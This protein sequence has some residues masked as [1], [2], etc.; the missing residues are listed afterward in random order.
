MDAQ[1][2][3]D[4]VLLSRGS[5]QLPGHCRKPFFTM[6]LFSEEHMD[7]MNYVKEV[8][9]RLSVPVSN[10]CPKIF[11]GHFQGKDYQRLTL[12]SGTCEF[13]AQQR[14]RWYKKARK[15]VPDGLELTNEMVANWFMG[16]GFLLT[17]EGEHVQ[18]GLCSFCFSEREN[19][20]LAEGLQKLGVADSHVIK[21][22]GS[23]E[24]RFE[25]HDSI[26]VLMDIVEPFILPSY[27]Y[28][29]KE[30]IGSSGRAIDG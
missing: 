16:D 4:G 7:W 10:D 12:S 20:Y 1:S 14:R 15:A 27:Q 6:S 13:V 23:W 30:L 8:L 5:I 21:S 22:H 11:R 24:I 29:I 25:S 19:R 2:V 26:N 18:A 28:E 3:F 17:Y 9:L